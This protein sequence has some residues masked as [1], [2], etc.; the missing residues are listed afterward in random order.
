M[1][2]RAALLDDL[3]HHRYN[4]KEVGSALR[5]LEAN[6]PTGARHGMGLWSGPGDLFP[7][8]VG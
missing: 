3:H 1:E 6:Y 4:K 8:G 5:W 7:K 2:L